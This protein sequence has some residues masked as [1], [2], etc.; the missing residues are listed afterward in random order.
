MM[1]T[2]WGNDSVCNENP[3]E[4]LSRPLQYVHAAAALGSQSLAV[5]SCSY[6]TVELEPCRKLLQP[7]HWGVRALQYAFVAAALGSQG[8]A[9]CSRNCCTGEPESCSML[10]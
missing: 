8:F 4:I 5:C 6:S 2:G 9:V 7:Q 1:F 10:L 3:S